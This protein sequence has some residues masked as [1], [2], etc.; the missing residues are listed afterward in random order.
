MSYVF[1][2]G[3]KQTGFPDQFFMN[4]NEHEL[5]I[6]DSRGWFYGSRDARNS[7]TRCLSL[8]WIWAYRQDYNIVELH[9]LVYQYNNQLLSICDG[10]Q[11]SFDQT[12]PFGRL[13]K[14][15]RGLGWTWDQDEWTY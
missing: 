12:G 4:E 11:D 3:R 9:R 5:G 1:A 15:W 13:R 7:G 2:V 8:S 6:P 14:V 10:T